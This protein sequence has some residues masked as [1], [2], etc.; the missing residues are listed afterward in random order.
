MSKQPV[1]GSDAVFGPGT[2]DTP[3]QSQQQQQQPL[4]ALSEPGR[5][6][7]LCKAPILEAQKL[8]HPGIVAMHDASY[9][10]DS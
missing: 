7:V 6:C 3:Q 2:R 8:L 9:F 5:D 1:K 10:I 4:R